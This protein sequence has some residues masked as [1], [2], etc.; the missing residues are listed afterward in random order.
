MIK[1][2]G[3]KGR[4]FKKKYYLKLSHFLEK[5]QFKEIEELIDD[6]LDLDFFIDPRKIPNRF[7]IIS[8]LLLDCIQ[9]LN[10][11]EIFNILR[12][13]NK[14]NLVDKDL[15]DSELGIINNIKKD[16]LLI[17]NLIDLFGNISNPFILFIREVMPFNL[18]HYYNNYFNEYSSY[19]NDGYDINLI[20]NY[21]ND[22]NIY[23]LN[24]KSLGNLEEFFN[25]FKKEVINHHEKFIE[26]K[27]ANKNH[28]ASPRILL[29]SYQK[30]LSQKE[31]NFYSLSMV[32]LYGIG[33][34]GYG[35]TF[36][37]P[38]GEV[39]EI[40]SDVKQNEAIVIKYKQFLTEQFLFKLK[41]DLLALK[42]SDSIIS[43][44]SIYL[45]ELLK[46]KKH[47]NYY[48]KDFITQR[49]NHFFDFNI[50]SMETKNNIQKLMPE[51]S[52]SITKI[53]RPIKMIDQFKLRMD[54]IA[55]NKLR[56]EDIAKLTSLKEK[57]NY[58]VLKER[59]FLQYIVDW[60]YQLYL[61]KK[62]NINL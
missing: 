60:F 42:I 49:I 15:N 40:C 44:L 43:E 34:Q 17:A 21:L 55:E 47:I 6:S 13:V 2:N 18:L 8:N 57:S 39:I 28:L 58:D 37:T 52:K 35:F 62:S 50:N 7:Q 20:L 10:L 45:L 61:E 54:L 48:K 51:I 23:G 30:I 3:L 5:G 12:F 53:L 59:L 27:F 32:T 41:K 29:N 1:Q 31:Y 25:L 14:L 9:T 36:S 56:S 46:S 16:S 4:D 22:Y 33:P 11:G 26:F 24:V 19:S 38:K